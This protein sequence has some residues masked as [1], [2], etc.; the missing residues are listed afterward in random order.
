MGQDGET[1]HEETL[2]LEQ[3]ERSGT[4]TPFQVE[5]KVTTGKAGALSNASEI[6][7][8]GPKSKRSAIYP[9]GSPLKDCCQNLVGGLLVNDSETTPTSILEISLVTRG[10]VLVKVQS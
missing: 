6:G 2:L 1:Q 5:K 4:P 3:Q 7:R 9:L 10:C 8:H